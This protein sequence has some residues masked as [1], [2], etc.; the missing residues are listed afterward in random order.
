MFL[1]SSIVKEYRRVLCHRRP[2]QSSITTVVQSH[3]WGVSYA[4]APSDIIWLVLTSLKLCAS[5]TV[6]VP[7]LLFACDQSQNLA[8]NNKIILFFYPLKERELS[9][10][11]LSVLILCMVPGSCNPYQHALE[12]KHGTPTD[13]HLLGE[14]PHRHIF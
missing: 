3:K 12:E 13:N 2:Q 9:I 4:P 14:N 10:H 11:P 7:T 8:Q 5:Q 6:R 1:F